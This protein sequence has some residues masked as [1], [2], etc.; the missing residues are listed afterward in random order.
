MR[1]SRRWVEMRYEYTRLE[2]LG[3]RVPYHPHNNV[4]YVAIMDAIVSCRVREVLVLGC[5]LG[6]VEYLLPGGI[7]CVSIDRNEEFIQMAREINRYTPFC[8]FHVGDIFRLEQV[9]GQRKFR[10]VMISEVIEHLE[11]DRLALQNACRHILPDGWLVL[12]V[13]NKNRFYNRLRRLR[14]RAPYLMATDH[15]RE[16]TFTGARRLL[17]ELGLSIVNWQGV[18]FDFP[19]PY[20]VEKYISPYSKLRFVLA[21]LFPR[22]ATYFLLVCKFSGV[23]RGRES[24]Q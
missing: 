17:E 6:I 15:R 2:L 14:G 21:A 13:P 9:L 8:D 12:T 10:L 19:R 20:Q 5:G 24:E 11:D 7:R 22:W 16:Y 1:R 18:W 3:A 23:E 4:R